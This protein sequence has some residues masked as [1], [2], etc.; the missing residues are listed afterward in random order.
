MKN[1]QHQLSDF[2]YRPLEHPIE[3]ITK[4]GIEAMLERNQADN[5]IVEAWSKFRGH[6]TQQANTNEESAHSL[7]EDLDTTILFA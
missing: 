6:K 7:P 2:D 3:C 1:A 5:K 4:V